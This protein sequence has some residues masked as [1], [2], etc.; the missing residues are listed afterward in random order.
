MP[1]LLDCPVCGQR[2]RVPNFAAGRITKCTAC[3]NAVRVREPKKMLED[4]EADEAAETAADKPTEAFS[5][6]EIGPR[7]LERLSGWLDWLAERPVRVL[8]VAAVVVACYVGVTSAKWALSKSAEAPVTLKEP[9]DPDWE[10]VGTS[11]ANERVRVTVQSVTTEQILIL[12]SGWSRPRKTPQAYLKIAL[13]IENLGGAE[14]KY[15]G[16]AQGGGDERSAKLKD[17]A[18]IAHQ[19]LNARIVGQAVSASIPPSGSIEDI[20]VFNNPGT[21]P[22]YLKLSLPA[23]AYGEK[24]DLRIKIPR[25]RLLD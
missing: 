7:S 4:S 17:D 8:G 5:I 16:W 25:T 2:L 12:P 14:L 9:E 6:S 18:G 24:G 23:E 11:D 1:I 10:S 22:R 3:G 19:Q 21:T 13:K 20:L 15:T